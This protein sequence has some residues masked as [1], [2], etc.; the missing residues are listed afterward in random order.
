MPLS[1]VAS[2][3]TGMNGGTIFEAGTADSEVLRKERPVLLSGLNARPATH[4]IR[5]VVI[6]AGHGGQ[7]AGAVNRSG[8]KEK[9]ITLDIALRVRRE[10]QARGLEVVMTRDSDVFVPLG[11]RA[12]IANRAKADFFVSIHANAASEPSLRGFE[13]YHLSEEADDLALAQDRSGD[14]EGLRTILWDLRESENRKES[15]SMTNHLMNAVSADVK[16]AVQRARAAAFYVLKQTECPAVLVETGY[17]TN[18][19]DEKF[20]RSPIFK[21]KLARAIAKGILDFKM[22]YESTDGFTR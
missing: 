2:V 6:D 7:D 18:P 9:N 8:L 19:E 1:A 13:I 5:K 3:P 16:T 20:L 14:S 21:K 11:K 17:V 4:F 10:L 15:L 12:D 22:E